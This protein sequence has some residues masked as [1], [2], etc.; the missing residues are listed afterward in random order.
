MGMQYYLLLFSLVIVLSCRST[1]TASVAPKTDHAATFWTE[2]Q[3]LCG[4]AY[5]GVIV[6]APAND[7]VFKNKRLVMHVRSCSEAR[8]RIPFIVGNDY[9]RTW[10]LTREGTRL[11]LKH[12]H[13]HRD[14]SED[15]VT[16]YGG[17]TPNS[18][19]ATVQLFPADQ[20]TVNI[21]PAAANNVWW[22][23]LVPGQYF[24]YNLRRMGTDRFF[25][26]R[27]DLSKEVTPPAA[28]WGW[29]D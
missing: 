3:Q 15:S 27:F 19:S 6:A 25:S 9:S 22:I 21:I 8:M 4:K 14:G 28:P 10:V 5:E 16:Q 12:D 23:E 17:L 26:I 18:G 7:T 2:L 1:H 29:K 24:T 13:R 20:H 11:Q